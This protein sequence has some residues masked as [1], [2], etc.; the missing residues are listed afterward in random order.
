MP[1]TV[2]IHSTGDRFPVGDGES[3]LAAARRQGIELPY[4]CA[5][6]TCGFCISRIIEGRIDYPDGHPL[7]LPD[8]EAG[9]GKGL[10]CVGHPAADLVIEPDHLG[11]QGEPWDD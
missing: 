4:G 7:A 9:A 8:D 5:N 1:F 11:E 6:G 2:T 10:C 3:I